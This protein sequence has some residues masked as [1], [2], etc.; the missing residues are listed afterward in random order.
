MS[1]VTLISTD[2]K[3]KQI[4]T[5]QL[6]PFSSCINYCWADECQL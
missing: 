1:R 6:G 5:W 4:D 2:M 3:Q